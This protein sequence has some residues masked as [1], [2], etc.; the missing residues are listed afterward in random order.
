[1]KLLL[2]QNLSFRLTGQLSLNFPGSRHVKDF[3]LTEADDELIWEFA[4]K[5]EYVIV[6]KD[7]DFMHRSLLRNHPPKFIFVRTGN[8]S[9]ADIAILISSNFRTIK[10]FI[11]DPLESMLIIA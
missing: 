4:A 7:S 3:G 8:C 9:N 11:Q 1:M 6:S 10:A 2:D 5:E